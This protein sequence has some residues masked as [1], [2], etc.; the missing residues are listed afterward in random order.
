MTSSYSLKHI[1]GV[2]DLKTT[3]KVIFLL[4][5]VI[6]Y[7]MFFKTLKFIFELLHQA[8]VVRDSDLMRFVFDAPP[9]EVRPKLSIFKHQVEESLPVL[10]S[11]AIYDTV[12]Y[13]DGNGAIDFSKTG[14][15][16]VQRKMLAI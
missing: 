1:L 3:S 12:Y 7:L 5:R 15:V 16:Y 14:L 13:T 2:A 9:G 6:A 10:A 4:C 8:V 11:L